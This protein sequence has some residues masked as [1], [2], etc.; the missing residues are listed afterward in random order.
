MEDIKIDIGNFDERLAPTDFDLLCLEKIDNIDKVTNYSLVTIEAGNYKT[1]IRFDWK[2]DKGIKE[3]DF[4]YVPEART[5]FFRSQNQWGAIDLE[6]KTM[7]RHES[8][9]WM[10]TIERK[11]DF[12]LVQDD[13]TAES[14]R[15]NGERI[16]SVPIDPP[17]EAKEFEDRIEYNSPIF[18]RQILKT[19]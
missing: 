15:L 9:L 18:A 8:S 7:K 11:R 3:S 1:K 10:P 6:S 14:T 12:I 19:K 4:L 2:E 5:I 13:L 16:H 17:T